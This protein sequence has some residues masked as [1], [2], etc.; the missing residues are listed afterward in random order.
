MAYP[1][2]NGGWRAVWERRQNKKPH[3]LLSPTEKPIQRQ[4]MDLHKQ[5]AQQIKEIN[6]EKLLN[7]DKYVENCNLPVENQEG[8]RT[9]HSSGTTKELKQHPQHAT[10]GTKSLIG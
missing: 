2:S 8:I 10:S 5:V 6:F 9:L 3:T 7:I 4:P 1:E